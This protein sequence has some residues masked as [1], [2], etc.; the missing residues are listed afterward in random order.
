MQ[1][2]RF[3]IVEFKVPGCPRLNG[4]ALSC[5]ANPACELH[6][7]GCPSD[8]RV[9]EVLSELLAESWT[10]AAIT[11][12]RRHSEQLRFNHKGEQADSP[13]QKPG[14]KEH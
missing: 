4:H 14:L 12:S 8:P 11:W 3:G 1:G 6:S 7:K 10:K 2:G 5:E 9:F 13:H